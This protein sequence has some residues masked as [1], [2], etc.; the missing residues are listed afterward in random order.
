MAKRHLDRLKEKYPQAFD[1]VTGPKYRELMKIIIA[2]NHNSVAKKMTKIT[3]DQYTKERDRS[4]GKA[5]T[6]NLPDVS[7]VLPKR[8]VS[9]MKAAD[10]GNLITD[11]L[12]DKLTGN[13]RKVLEEPKYMR[14][15]GALAGTLKESAINDFEKSIT[16]TFENYRKKDP[17]IGIPT[18]VHAIAVTEVRTVV[19]EIKNDYAAAVMRKNP[20]VVVTKVWKHNPGLSKEPRRDHK[21]LDG[22]EIGI[23]EKFVIH[24]PDGKTYYAQHPHAPGLPPEQSIGCNCE[25]VYK[26][27]RKSL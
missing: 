26:I 21:A 11:N 25:A 23:N 24:S 9:I 12:R 15:R 20:D 7:S 17:R 5:K 4:G 13:L 6:L 16:K 14:R 10:T 22:V 3:K 19:D 27:Q 1:D 18:N 2:E 8:S